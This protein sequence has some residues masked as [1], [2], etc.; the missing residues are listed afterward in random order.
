MIKGIRS[1]HKLNTIRLQV[2]EMHEPAT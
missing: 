1:N 2:L